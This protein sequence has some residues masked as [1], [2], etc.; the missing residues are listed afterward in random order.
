MTGEHFD[1]LLLEDNA[2]DA[3]RLGTLL[4]NPGSQF[5]VTHR[6]SLVPA[7]ELLAAQQFDA[8]I[9]D[10]SQSG[11]DLSSVL[12]A[13]HGYAPQVPV[14][15][16][17]G[18]DANTSNTDITVQEGAQDYL[19]KGELDGPLL[20]R[21]VHYAIER[22]R[23]KTAIHVL[24]LNDDLTALYNRRGFLTLAE[25]MLK[26]ALRMPEH[27]V[28][29]YADIDQFKR[30]NDHCGRAAG[31][32]A[33]LAAADIFRK[34]FRDSDLIARL[35]SDEFVV[36]AK[37]G[38]PEAMDILTTRLQANLDAY[39]TQH[40]PDFPLTFSIGIV[41]YDP[42]TPCT[43][44]QLLVRADQEMNANKRRKPLLMTT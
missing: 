39:N 24:S 43:I 40:Q 20:I 15:V 25:H 12:H 11:N 2:E 18:D 5:S 8:I 27:F 44:D 33:L 30:L 37:L 28:L 14:I 7:L 34:S 17:T 16:L 26:L 42:D 19:V 29:L 31:D 3:E 1:I 35:G 23:L 36:L 21:A 38:F 6:D 10:L 13:L 9:I 32:R 41:R 4:K 22:Q